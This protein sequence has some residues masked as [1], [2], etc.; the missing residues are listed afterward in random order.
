[1]VPRLA[2]SS[3]SSIPQLGFGL[4]KVDP[5][6]ATAASLTALEAGYRHLD[7]AALYGNE[8]EVGDAVK[9]SGLD[10]DEVFV[11]SKIWHNRLDDVEAALQESTERV[12]LGPLDLVL[13]H[14]PA[15]SSTQY[16]DAWARLLE[17]KQD[18]AVREVGVSNFTVECLQRVID[19]TGVAP[20]INQIELHP[21][22]Q[23]AELR[24]LHAEHG[25]LTEAW[26]PLARGLSG[27]LTDP[28][29]TEIAD[30]HGRTPAQVVLQWHVALGNVVIPKSVTPERIRENLDVFGFE[31]DGDELAAI[32][33]L[34]DPAG[35]IGPDPA[36]FG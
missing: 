16:V 3:T 20:P 19:A 30:R 1:M 34:D 26:S 21:R 28:V 4:F 8:A 22:F 6:G 31:L 27:V 10:R 33:G 24:A 18:G 35:R 13:I 17:L 25:I 5:G 7:T 9:R 29:I 32:A 2:L 11:T 15:P 12:G 23:Q 36:T 14:W